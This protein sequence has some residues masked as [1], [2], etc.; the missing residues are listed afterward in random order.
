MNTPFN[1]LNSLI[2]KGRDEVTA[3]IIA[4]P[5]KTIWEAI[6]DNQALH[7][8]IGVLATS[9]ATIDKYRDLIA[10]EEQNVE[11]AEISIATI[12][13]V[14]PNNEQIKLNRHKVSPEHRSVKAIEKH[15]AEAV[16]RNDTDLIENFD[17]MTVISEDELELKDW[18]I[19]KLGY[20]E[21]TPDNEEIFE[22]TVKD[23]EGKEMRAVYFKNRNSWALKKYLEEMKK[24]WFRIPWHEKD[25]DWEIRTKEFK[26][27]FGMIVPEWTPDRNNALIELLWRAFSGY[28]R[29][30]WDWSNT[31]YE[32]NFWSCS[33]ASGEDN[34]LYCS[35]GR[36]NGSPVF[37]NYS[38]EFGFGVLLFKDKSSD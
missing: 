20:P 15:R 1:A 24:E 19:V 27:I 34:A 31:G 38:R 22:R 6:W 23:T 16:E 25:K 7:D 30:D 9:K 10:L 33:P 2:Q 13:W 3:E 35:L 12:K 37:N 18:T 5:I 26:R 8:S 28:R 17:S 32:E 21:I 4:N 14:S 11:R 36:G 29:T